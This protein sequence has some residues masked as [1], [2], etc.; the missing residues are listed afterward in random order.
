MQYDENKPVTDDKTKNRNN[1]VNNYDPVNLRYAWNA[2]HSFL[3]GEILWS[4][5]K[6]FLYLRGKF[7]IWSKKD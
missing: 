6:N 1:I 5:G 7:N 4:T 2:R 3:N